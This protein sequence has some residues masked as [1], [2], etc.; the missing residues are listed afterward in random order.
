MQDESFGALVR[1]LRTEADLT[2]EAL[3]EASGVSDRGI[4]DIERGVSRAP[5][6]RTVLALADGLGLDDDA[7]AALLEAARD[8]RRRTLDS[9]AGSRLPVPAALEDFTGRAGD[10]LAVAAAL[11]GSTPGVA[12]AVVL[13]SGPP[14][15]G[16]TT[17]A[18]RVAA[19]LAPDFDDRV[20]L[21]L[22]GLDA[23]PVA[24]DDVVRRL[25]AALTASPAPA[26]ADDAADRLRDALVGRRVLLVLDNAASEEQVRAA[27]PASGPAAVLVTSR[28]TLAGLAG[29]RRFVLGTLADD[30]AVALLRRIVPPEA[31]GPDELARLAALCVDVPLALRIAGN[32]LAVRQGWSVA[33]LVA[34]LDAPDRRLDGLRAG[35]LQ[36]R[37]AFSSSFEQLGPGAQRMFRRLALALADAPTVGTGLAA[38]LSGEGLPRAEDLLDEL[39]D[40]S[41]VQPSGDERFGLHDLLREFAASELRA[42]EGDD[43]AAATRRRADAW[44]LATA[45]RAGRWFEPEHEVVPQGEEAL[46]VVET[47]DDA[48]HWLVAEAESWLAALRRAADGGAGTVVVEVAEALHWF[49]DLWPHWRGWGEVFRLSARAAAA[50]G[51]DALTATHEGYLAWSQIVG[52]DD[53]DAARAS[54]R[55]AL[56]AASRAGDDA[57]LGWAHYYVG[58]ASADPAVSRREARHAAEH[59]RAA[60][61]REALPQALL[62]A[63]DAQARLGDVDGAVE[64]AREVL[65]V[66]ADP[67]TRPRAQV[68]EFTAASAH[69]Y[70]VAILGEAGRWAEVLE[71]APEAVVLAETLGVTRMVALARYWRGRALLEVEGPA[72]AAPDLQRA[73]TLR[74]EMGDEA[75]ASAIRDLLDARG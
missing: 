19:D 29:A 47:A 22:R 58:W 44:L 43:A 52:L 28:R 67:A 75:A 16:K 13:V 36:V 53:M 32:R 56:D 54:A 37:A 10:R 61:D 2:L 3:A 5:Q 65:D 40:L 12:P 60:G 42:Q 73:L 49:S 70:V 64:T 50:S 14:G 1:R 71:L 23:Q 21:D 41:L 34:R 20:F 8:A 38:A 9:A 59:F 69:G 7:R 25:C 57:A 48:R 15:F 72:A 39:V 74:E 33:R 6:R 26:R 4:G 62:A 18:A 31:G 51:D 66:L 24:P 45:S 11:R 27:L 35:D 63:S 55:R 68:A 46:V 17:L 30:D